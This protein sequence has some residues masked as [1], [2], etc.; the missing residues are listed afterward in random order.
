MKLGC[1]MD[2]NP[3]FW[4]NDDNTMT[5]QK[6]LQKIG[7]EDAKEATGKKADWKEKGKRKRTLDFAQFTDWIVANNITNEA[8]FWRLAGKEKE[9]NQN[10]TLWNYGGQIK[11]A[12]M[13][14]KAQKGYLAAVRPDVFQFA[15]RDDSPFPLSDF[16]IP[17]EVENWMKQETKT[18]SLIIQ[19]TG[20]LGKTQMAKAILASFG[21]YF[22]VDSL[23]TIK[24][25][26]FVNGEA[27]LCDDVT[28]SDYTI[29]QVK[30][31]LDI[32][33][34]RAGDTLQA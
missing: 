21:K 14:V 19:G 5:K 26:F 1:H 33:C 25:L 27:L 28:L 31:L 32:S 4:P 30:S 34:E 16:R 17:A 6:M 3:L 29:D 23:D 9:E 20:G 24:H 2:Q 13:V 12:A 10:P 15:S 18:R 8:E 11:V 7:A 22:F